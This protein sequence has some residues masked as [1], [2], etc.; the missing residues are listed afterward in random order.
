MS[1]IFLYVRFHISKMKQP[2]ELTNFALIL[3]LIAYTSP[4]EAS[5]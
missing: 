2:Q 4:S 3:R 5:D 1:W